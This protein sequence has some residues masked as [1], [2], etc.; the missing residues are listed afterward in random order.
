MSDQNIHLN[1]Y[2]DLTSFYKYYIDLFNALYQLKTENE[3]ELNSIYNK[4]KTEM[5]DSKKHHPQ[6]ILEDIL[7]I[8]PF[9]IRYKKSY[10]TLAKLISDDYHITEANNI[11][12]TSNYL[13]YKEYGIKLFLS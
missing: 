6:N 12:F 1:K 13:F 10:L 4:L 5:I 8:I 11:P 7:N 2:I 9:N 3:E